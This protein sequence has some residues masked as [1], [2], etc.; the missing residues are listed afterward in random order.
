MTAKAIVQSFYDL[1][2]ATS[3]N[4]MDKFHKD[5]E[6]HWNSSTGFTKLDYTGIDKM[7][8]GVRESYHSF[9]YKL[10]HLLES[11]NT[12]TA[13]YT[14]YVTTIERPEKEEPLAHFISIWE[15]KDDKLY[16]GWEMSQ[17]LDETPGNISSYSEIKI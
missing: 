6:L 13:R 7:M 3:E 16:R 10:S 17:L 9:T 11:D 8:T 15:V 2:L 14:V 12:V 1:D 4:A 5:C